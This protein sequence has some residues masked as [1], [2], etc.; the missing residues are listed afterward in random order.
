M[1]N[2]I[3]KKYTSSLLLAGGFIV[4]VLLVLSEPAHGQRVDECFDCHVSL[5]TP[6]AIKFKY[7]VHKRKGLSCAD[8]HGGNRRSDDMDVAMSKS[9]GFIGIPK[10]NEISERCGNCHNS[11]EKMASFGYSGPT[12]QYD[13]LQASVHGEGSIT[14]GENIAQCT[15]CHGAHGIRNV[16][17]P[18]SP[19]SPLNVVNTC[20]RCHDDPAYMRQYNPSLPTDQL[21]KYRT[22]VHGMLHAKND[23]KVATCASCHTAHTIK[24]PDDATSSV[25]A[26]NIPTT[27]GKC[28]SDPEYMAQYRIPT[29]QVE[30]YEKSVHG[31]ALLEKHDASAP[32]CNDCHGNHGAIPPGVESISNVCG[33]CHALNAELFRKSPHK[34]VFDERNLPE[35]ETC[36]GNHGI[37]P[38]TVEMISV[39]KD[40]LC[41]RCH[42]SDSNPKGYKAAREMRMLLDSLVSSYANAERILDV[43][44]QKGMEIEDERFALRDVNQV[45]LQA[46]TAVHAFNLTKFHETIDKGLKIAEDTKAAGQGAIDEFYFRR[47]GLA[48]ATLIITFLAI[49]LFL[50]IKKIERH[51]KTA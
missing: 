33:T 35:C 3:K 40:G 45:R 14:A 11:E 46:R 7:D 16:T 21:S 10:K 24:P 43:A 8:C 15:T 13:N 20:A 9:A 29:D 22:S 31:I 44:E 37:Q 2:T 49:M 36:H 38:A 39:E 30:Q 18:R 50:Y 34:K 32:T 17:D 41:A 6:Q 51:Q 27:C 1:N 42:S 28:H 47:W 23:K 25:Y 12:G 5:D 19:V 4:A 48:V 26:E